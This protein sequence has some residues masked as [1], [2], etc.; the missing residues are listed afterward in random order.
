MKNL[1]LALPIVMLASVTPVFA[2][3]NP[4]TQVEL[5]FVQNA[6]AVVFA[7]STLTLKGVSPSVIFFS[8]RPQRVAGHVALPRFLDAWDEGKDNF[9][10]D[11]PNA[12]LSIVGKGEVTSVV[13]EIANPQLEGDELSYEIVQIL[14][15]ELPATGGISSLFIDG[16]FTES[17]KQGAAKGAVTGAIFGAAAGDVGTGAAIGAG[18]GL[19]GNMGKEGD[20]I[21]EP[22]VTTP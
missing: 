10:E 13:I 20:V 4:A 9:A 17:E 1:T 16:L 8:D 2:Q 18:V 21:Q 12:A 3:P 19:I 22:E 7:D 6:E 11:P 14:D 15:G 5:L